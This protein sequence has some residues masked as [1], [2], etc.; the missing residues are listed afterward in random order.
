MESDK[1]FRPNLYKH[2]WLGEPNNT[3]GKIYQDWNIID[4]IPHEAELVKRGLDFGYTTDPAAIVDLY[5]YNGGYIASERLYRRGMKNNDLGNF[6]SNLDRSSTT[7][8]ADSSEPKSIKEVSEYG[9][10]I[11]GVQKRPDREA[12][13]KGQDYLNWSIGF[14]QQQKISVTRSSKNLID[15]YENYYWAT[16]K[17]GKTTGKPEGGRDHALDALRYAFDGQ[18]P[19][20]FQEDYEQ[21]QQTVNFAI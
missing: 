8:M 10:P 15:E 11:I 18:R 4:E 12:A 2:K 5:Y 16:D 21:Y 19:K 1:E 20:P 7:V 14:V 17:D 3:E 9:V 13:R 6:L